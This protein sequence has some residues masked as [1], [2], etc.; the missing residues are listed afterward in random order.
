MRIFLVLSLCFAT[1]CSWF[2]KE[3][4]A[5][6][7][8]VTT[9]PAVKANDTESVCMNA[10]EKTISELDSNGNFQALHEFYKNHSNCMDGAYAQGI[11]G[12]ISTALDAFWKNLP[13]LAKLFDADKEFKNFFFKSIGCYVSA[14]EK[15][16]ANV[17]VKAQ[18]ECPATLKDLCG[19]IKSKAEKEIAY[20]KSQ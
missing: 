1:S 5:P 17:V 10:F 6:Q 11:E 14:T 20:A 19:E 16:L 3:P 12:G 7:A 8:K 18:N 9:A 2:N 13:D 4:I 15:Q